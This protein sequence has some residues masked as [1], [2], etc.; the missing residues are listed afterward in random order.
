VVWTAMGAQVWSGPKGD[1]QKAKIPMQKFVGK[2]M[3]N[4]LIVR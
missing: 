4:D 2:L 1:A 3:I